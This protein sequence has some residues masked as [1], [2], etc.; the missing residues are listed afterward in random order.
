MESLG[1]NP[2]PPLGQPSLS[3]SDIRLWSTLCHLGGLGGLIFPSFGAVLG[4]LVFWLL[5]RNDHPA[6]DD[7]GKEALNFQLSILVY[8]WA[9]G[10]LG[11]ATV[12]FLV[13]FVFIGLAFLAGVFGL[14]MAVVAAVKASH[15]QPFRYPLTLR[16]IG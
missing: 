3:E 9:L 15:G 5:K 2:A 16:L 7:H 10:L 8:S 13:G 12:I 11:A 1:T 14:V 4:P 6:I